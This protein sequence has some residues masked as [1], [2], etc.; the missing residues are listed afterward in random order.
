MT[1]RVRAAELLH[2]CDE[3]V[4][5]GIDTRRSGAFGNRERGVYDGPARI[6]WPPG[7]AGLVPESYAQEALKVPSP[8]FTGGGLLP[9]L[10]GCFSMGPA[11]DMLPSATPIR[12]SSSTPSWPGS[13]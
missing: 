2:L 13:G 12:D 3:R 6:R 5:P 1:S 10:A 9:S 4:K 7:S 8:T 11:Y